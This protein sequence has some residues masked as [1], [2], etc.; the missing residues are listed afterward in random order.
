MDLG[1]EF[2]G[3]N[4]ILTELRGGGGLITMRWWLNETFSANT[5]GV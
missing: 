5:P 4:I 1:T 2:R 3:L